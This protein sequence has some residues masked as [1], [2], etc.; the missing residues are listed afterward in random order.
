VQLSKVP[1]PLDTDSA[2]LL[3]AMIRVLR[4]LRRVDREAGQSG[5]RLSALSVLA[6]A[7]PLSL[8]RLAAA[9]QV[10]LPSASRLVRD[11]ER[12][13]LVRRRVDPVD[14]RAIVLAVTARGRT[15]MQK[16]RR[17]RVEALESA[18]A[19]LAPAEREAL[20]AVVP[21]LAALAESLGRGAPASTAPRHLPK[22][23]RAR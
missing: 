20:A 12:D 2:A 19:G 3:G 10:S 23:G 17:R 7:G 11:L 6:F 21:A 8:S 1:K 14:A 13:G 9:E 18:R 4:R 22:R 5:P 16:G 15:L